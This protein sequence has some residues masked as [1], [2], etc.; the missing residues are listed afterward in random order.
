MWKKWQLFYATDFQ[1][2][3]HPCFTFC[4][5]LG[6]FLYRNN[7][8]TFET[9]KQ[10]CILTTV[11][12]NTLCIYELGILCRIN[13]IGINFNIV[14]FTFERNCFFTLNGFIVIITYILNGSRHL[15]QNI[16]EISLRLP[17]DSYRKL[18]KLIHAKDIFGFFFLIGQTTF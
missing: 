13:I 3:M 4:R 8:S 2:L 7:A 17:P 12:I 5:I 16:M 9:T 1:S 11:I 18:S 14:G 6:I 10:R 15:L